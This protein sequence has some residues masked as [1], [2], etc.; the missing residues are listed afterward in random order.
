MQKLV[1]QNADGV[2]L[3]LTSGNYGI[4]EW[5][6]F[7]NTGLNI[8]SQQVPF[9]DGG[10]F[11][12]ALIEQRELS[13]TL[14]IQDR[15]NLELRYQQR[16][17]LISALNPK[18]GEGYLIY[19][20]DFISKRIKCIPQ[21]PIFETHNSDMSGTPKA[22]LTWTACEPYWEDLEETVVEINAGEEIQ[23]NNTGDIACSIKADI[24]SVSK[25]PVLH[26]KTTQKEVSLNGIFTQD[27]L[28]DTNVGNKKIEMGKMDFLTITGGYLQACCYGQGKYIYGGIISYIENAYT[29][30][31]KQLDIKEYVFGIRFLK[32]NFII[33]TTQAVL[34]SKNG[35][36]WEKISILSGSTFYDVAYGNNIY[37]IVGTGG[38]VYS[39]PDGITW[40]SRTSGVSVDLNKIIYANGM[41]VAVGVNGKI[42]TSSDGITWTSRTSG[43]SNDLYGIC[44]SATIGEY[45]VVG[46]PEIIITSP[47]G[48]T[49]VQ[50]TSGGSNG[51]QGVAC[52]N[53][54]IVAVGYNGAIL[55]SQDGTNWEEETGVVTTSILDII[56]ANNQFVATG[57]G[58]TIIKSSDGLQWEAKASITDSNIIDIVY[59]NDLFVAIGTQGLIITSSDKDNWVKRESNVNQNLLSIAYSETLGLFVA[60]GNNGYMLK[61]NDGINWSYETISF[62]FV[63]INYINGIFI[64]TGSEG[65]ILTSSDGDTWTQQNSGV[66]VSLYNATYKNGLYI[67]IGANGTILTSPDGV[68]WT[69]R[70]SGV[71]VTL[72]DIVCSED[73][74]VAVGNNN[75]II[76][77]VNGINWVQ[78]NLGLLDSDNFYSVTY[79]KGLFLTVRFNEGSIYISYDGIEWEKQ[80]FK[81]G[82]NL[83]S[84]CFA[85]DGF[86]IGG[87]AGIIIKSYISSMQNVIS[88]L[89]QTS[90][91][92]FNIIK[93]ENKIIFNTENNTKTL[94]TYRQ[95]YIGV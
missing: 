61:S 88:E 86:V 4:T 5:E 65:L 77:S 19:T 69:P 18:L 47:D 85:E 45:I 64:I 8:Q 58:G 92:T 84:C 25:N 57:T 89:T 42:I 66:N 82:G 44:F 93:G 71:N 24:K 53:T 78:R 2:E 63:S 52:N 35:T 7:S 74:I 83:Y 80:D 6:G 29:G 21:I 15:N 37:V 10:V 1:W 68:N 30:E 75:T 70:T 59:G 20:N 48:V 17:E 33:T 26:N 49:W 55:I 16:R 36:E 41:F 13:V 14:A 32:D 22:T 34:L 43:V 3:D 90:D 23:I 54:E 60:V 79:G 67:I 28:I 51:L 56:Y 50:K 72:R 40:T 91:M 95:K 27:L 73:I 9:Q 12:D 39:S 31:I 76:T 94:L 81:T 87:Q 38:T 62:A 11:L 46:E